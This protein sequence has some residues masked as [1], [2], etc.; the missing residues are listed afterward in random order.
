MIKV[1]NPNLYGFSL[2]DGISTD[3][4]AKFNVGEIGAMSRDIFWMVKVLVQR[5]RNDKN[6][7]FEN[8]WKLVSV[9]I[10]SND[11]CSDICFRNNPEKTA[12]THEQ[13]L[14]KALRYLRDNL[15][16]TIV[17]L[18]ITPSMEIL[19]R[20]KG[21]PQHCYSTHYFECPCFFGLKFS[22]ERKRWFNIIEDWKRREFS[23][24]D[25]EE[26]HNKLDF[27][28][29]AQPFLKSVTWPKT[30]S[31][32]SDVSYMS[33]DCFHMS[34]K[35]YSRAVNSLWNNMF[36]PYGNKSTNWDREF[37]NVKCPTNEMPFIRTKFN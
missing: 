16:R 3:K 15:P 33:M 20:L 31:G 18:I 26:F 24:A 35:G 30:S 19:T 28:V 6:V 8:H 13:D 25:R 17:N 9:L 34:Q 21:K 10:G 5:M 23:V 29:V 11:V 22:Y 1:Y 14:I 7:D 37:K 2:N 27:S 36:E 32:K 4:S 12:D